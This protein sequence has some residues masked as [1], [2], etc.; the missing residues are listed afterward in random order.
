[1]ISVKKKPLPKRMMLNALSGAAMNVLSFLLTVFVSE[2]K[3]MQKKMNV[4]QG[5]F[6]GGVSSNAQVN[7]GYHKM[8][9]GEEIYRAPS[10]LRTDNGAMIVFLGNQLC[11][12]TP[13]INIDKRKQS[14]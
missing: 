3:V 5:V 1:M 2:L 10:V 8:L 6:V 12:V 7:Q 13:S 9:K 11:Q 14:F 4:N